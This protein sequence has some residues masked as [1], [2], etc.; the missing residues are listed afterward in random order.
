M[1]MKAVCEETGLTRKTILFYEEQ[2]FISPEKTRINQR[3]Y[4]EYSD[5]DVQSL[6]DIAT[7][8]KCG[9]SIDEIKQMRA[10]PETIKPIFREY[11]LRLDSQKSELEELLQIAGKIDEAD[12]CDIQ[13]LLGQVRSASNQLPLPEYDLKPHFLYLDEMEEEAS[14]VNK[15]SKYHSDNQSVVIDQDHILMD[16]RYGKKKLLDDLKSDLEEVPHYGASEPDHSPVWLD[17][18]KGILTIALILFFF[19]YIQS[20]RWG[21]FSEYAILNIVIIASL[22]IVIVGISLL[23]KRLKKK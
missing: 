3:D 2:G 23:Q 21:L 22:I 4:R 18:L 7:L 19:N 14:P 13:S 17:V 9:F 20:T 8:R 1:K 11:K 15:T 12:L 10:S 5:T 16:A 6:M